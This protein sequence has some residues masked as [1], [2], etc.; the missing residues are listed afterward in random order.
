MTNKQPKQQPPTSLQLTPEELS[1]I[2]MMRRNSYQEIEIQVQD[3][4]ITSVDQTLKY[5]RKKGG[6]LIG[7]VLN[8]APFVAANLGK[9]S[10]EEVS[11]IK[12]IR[13]K[14]FQKVTVN[15]KNGID[16]IYQTLKFRKTK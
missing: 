3:S 6:G 8:R 11:V 5:R 9:L 2:T 14:P 12:K 10:I 15:I 13:E 7:G 4:V 16:S 1:I